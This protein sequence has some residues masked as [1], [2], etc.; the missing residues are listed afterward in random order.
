MT[1]HVLY[2]FMR[3]DMDSMTRGRA[4]AQAAHAA[5]QFAKYVNINNEAYRAWYNA[6]NGFGTTIVLDVGKADIGAIYTDIE[7]VLNEQ[8]QLHLNGYHIGMV[9]DDTYPVK[10]GSVTHL[11]SY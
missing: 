3:S 1:N 9:H 6:G 11:V 4:C 5:N 10:D 7:D 2:I 8:Y